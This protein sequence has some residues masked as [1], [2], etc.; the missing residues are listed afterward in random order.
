MK[1]CPNCGSAI[2]IGEIRCPYCK[3]A[4]VDLSYIPLNEPFT[5]RINVG[6]NEKPQIIVQTVMTTGVTITREPEC[7]Y[8]ENISG[9]L[10]PVITSAPT[11]Y[12]FEFKSVN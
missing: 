11:T 8:C 6:T 5:L 9:R 2:E 7:C 10:I 4:Y 12:E 3:T 1:N